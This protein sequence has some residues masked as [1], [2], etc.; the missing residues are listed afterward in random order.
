M[1]NSSPAQKFKPVTLTALP[2]DVDASRSFGHWEF[3]ILGFR[4][5]MNIT[6][7]EAMLLHL[8]TYSSPANF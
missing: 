4:R 2:S 1:E 3:I 6:D 7:E 8:A 5:P